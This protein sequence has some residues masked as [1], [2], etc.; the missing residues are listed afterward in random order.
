MSHSYTPYRMTHFFLSIFQG[1]NIIMIRFICLIYLLLFATFG[2]TA[3]NVEGVY[4]TPDKKG[5][6]EIYEQNGEL[7]ARSVCC[8]ASKKDSKNPNP[9]LRD[10]SR[11]GINVMN[12]FKLKKKNYY[13]S[14]RIY[15]PNN[16]KT[17]RARMWVLNGGDKIKVKG[18]IGSPILGKTIICERV[19]S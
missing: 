8:D 7:M 4:W 11:I 18:F 2:L 1:Q 13:T 10:R 3:Q 12:G 14:G 19:Q 9:N 15:N 17:Y 5:K 16:G 6:I